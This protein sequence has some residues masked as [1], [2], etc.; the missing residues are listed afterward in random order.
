M[1]A[2]VSSELNPGEL[3]V[4]PGTQCSAGG[5]CYRSDDSDLNMKLH[6]LI[7]SILLSVT[8]VVVSAEP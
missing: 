7:G 2:V 1:N 8:E 6:P 4:Q 3:C 5:C